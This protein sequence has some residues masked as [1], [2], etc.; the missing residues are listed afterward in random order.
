MVRIEKDVFGNYFV[1]CYEMKNDIC[2]VATRRKLPK[3]KKMSGQL[4]L[5]YIFDKKLREAS[6]IETIWKQKW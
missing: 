1:I 6:R 4:K 2:L 5:N 3:L